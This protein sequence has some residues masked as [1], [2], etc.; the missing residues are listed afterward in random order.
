LVRLTR[1]IS[2]YVVA[3]AGVIMLLIGLVPRGRGVAGIPHPVLGGAALAMFGHVAVGRRARPCPGW[4]STTTATW[5]SS[6]STV[7]LA[8]LVT[9]QPDLAKALPGW[10]DVIFGSGITLGSAD[11]DNRAQC[12]FS[13]RRRT[14]RPAVAGHPAP[15]L[16]R[17]GQVQPE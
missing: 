7:G 2:R 15:A 10:A 8:L 1:V 13:T 4:T 16:V 14:S 12:G 9:A 5:C 6:E 11:R 17:L 3:A